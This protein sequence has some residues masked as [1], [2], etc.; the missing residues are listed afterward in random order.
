MPDAPFALSA[1]DDV[2]D[3]VAAW[4][5]WLAAER[6]ASRHTLRA[7]EGDVRFFLSFLTGYHEHKP[8]LADLSHASLADFR[9][10]LSQKAG[11]GISAGSR[12]RS[13]SAVR[14][15]YRWLGRGGRAE[16]AAIG[17]MRT[18]KKNRSLPRP[19]SAHDAK[20]LIASAGSFSDEEWIA[21]RDR[22]LFMVLY[23]CGLRLSEALSLT[24]ASLRTADM[25]TITGKGN[26]Q[27]VVPLLPAVR[28]AVES[29]LH[30]CPHP[31]PEG[32]PVFVGVRGG[33]LNPAVAERQM[34]ALRRLMGLPDSATPHALRHSFATHLLS[35]GA[36]LR[37]IQELL[38]HASL[39][40]TQ[41]YTDVEAEQILGIYEKAHPRAHGA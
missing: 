22:A 32:A 12:A 39:S 19:L 40:T 10:Y 31:L 16:N 2:C 8:A 11:A 38:G 28:G 29:Y 20:D 9:A 24:P 14:N 34:R 5:S 23:G 17:M 6:R 21:L 7:Y 27:R 1:A 33:P 41:R 36:D 35:G 37:V 30:A 3:A 18:P 15:F 25:L 4:L 13:L 26:K